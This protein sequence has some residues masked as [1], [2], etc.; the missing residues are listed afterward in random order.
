MRVLVTIVLLCGWIVAAPTR[1]TLE[2]A[3]WQQPDSSGSTPPRFELR[4]TY[5]SGG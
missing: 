1:S 2:A 4:W 5:E 3:S